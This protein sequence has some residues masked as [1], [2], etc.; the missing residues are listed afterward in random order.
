MTRLRAE[1]LQ[2]AG[3]DLMDLRGLRH[4]LLHTKSIFIRLNPFHRI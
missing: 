3:A 4:L 1:A 2:R